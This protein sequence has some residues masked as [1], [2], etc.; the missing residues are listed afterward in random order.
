MNDV[1]A[2][3]SAAR[4]IERGCD[5]EY[6]HRCGRCQAVLDLRVALAA[7]DNN[8]ASIDG[9]TELALCE[10]AWLILKPNQL[11]RFVPRPGCDACAQAAKAA[12]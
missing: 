1:S 8:Q 11:Y 5:C 6:D 3:V 12:S 7:V 10:A 2:L 4:R 9:I